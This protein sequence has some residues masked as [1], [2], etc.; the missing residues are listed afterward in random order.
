MERIGTEAV[1]V[2]PRIIGHA[3]KPSGLHKV[4]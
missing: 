2:P 3:T 4:A 1:L